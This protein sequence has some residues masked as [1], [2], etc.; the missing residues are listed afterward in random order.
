MTP[1]DNIKCGT[2]KYRTLHKCIH[3]AGS[4]RLAVFL[5]AVLIILILFGSLI[6]Q[7]GNMSVRDI[8]QW[9]DRHPVISSMLT[10]IG[11]FHVYQSWV[12]LTIMVLL[13]LNTLT[14]T[15]IHLLKDGLGVPSFGNRL[16]KTG[17]TL[18]H[19][20]IIGIM[21]GGFLSAGMM[22]SGSIILT[23]GESYTRSKTPFSRLIKGP[24]YKDN[25]DDSDFEI[26]LENLTVEHADNIHHVKT[27]S[28]ITIK[29]PGKD[30]VSETITVNRPIK[31]RNLD[32]TQDITGYSARIAARINSTKQPLFHAFFALKTFQ[33]AKSKEYRN[34]IDLPKREK[35]MMN[36]Y[37]S[38]VI[39][40]GQPLK[41]G[42]DA[43]NPVIIMELMD[44]ENR[45][46]DTKFLLLGKTISIGN[47]TFAFPE[48]R[49][50]T[51]LRLVYDPGTILVYIFLWLTLFGLTLRYLP[52]I[53][54]WLKK[55]PV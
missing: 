50:W 7:E 23:E 54:E 49:Q 37:P 46:R 5:I 11:L 39:K 24:F 25:G 34:Y 42:E 48:I 20:S 6:P 30:P 9:Q 17:F 2:I 28:E 52:D 51:E 26:S 16:R 33:N 32:I 22:M 45:I 44:S 35:M 36:L 40:D 3:F 19:I 1:S 14:C 29:E 8:A 21:A 41:T 15:V 53:I 55:K 10:P 27:I 18:L 43:V 4:A 31:F 12:C 38:H 47:Y 13:A